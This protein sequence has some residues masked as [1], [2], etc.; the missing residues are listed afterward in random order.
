MSYQYMQQNA[1][2]M[3]KKTMSY[4]AEYTQIYNENSIILTLWF[5]VIFHVILLTHCGLFKPFGDIYLG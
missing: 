1:H 5:C 4:V 2:K 3:I